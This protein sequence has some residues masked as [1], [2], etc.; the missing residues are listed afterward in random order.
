MAKVQ[1]GISVDPSMNDNI[2]RL[3]DAHGM[4]RP[5]FMVHLAEEAINADLHGRPLFEVQQAPPTPAIDPAMLVGLIGQLAK[6]EKRLAGVLRAHDERDAKLMQVAQVNAQ[7]IEAAQQL[8]SERISNW[9]GAT[10]GPYAKRLD[11]LTATVLESSA[12]VQA[13][14][15]E[16]YNALP[17]LLIAQPDFQNV[18]RE[19]LR[20][21][22]LIAEGRPS[23][24]YHV[25]ENITLGR[26][27]IGWMISNFCLSMIYL[28]IFSHIFPSWILAQPIA[29]LLLLG[30]GFREFCSSYSLGYR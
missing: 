29:N 6:L 19:L 30:D 10:F 15:V 2:Q 24:V 23:N 26:S 13:K 7:A 17:K 11:Q 16:H 12:G 14:L 4:S 18:V 8:L 22:K 21:R 27:A 20:Q 28:I 3:A 9:L 25:F 1:I 5:Q